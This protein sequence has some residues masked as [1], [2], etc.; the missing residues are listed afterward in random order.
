MSWQRVFAVHHHDTALRSIVLALLLLLLS[1]SAAWMEENTALSPS[2]AG[3]SLALSSYGRRFYLTTSQAD[4]ASALAA[5]DA[6]YHM[7]S[8]WEIAD[9]S[10]LVYDTGRGCSGADAGT[11]P[12]TYV[13]GWA[14]TGYSTANGT[15]M[16]GMGNCQAWTSKSGT[17]Y[18]SIATLS[19]N[20]TGDVKI[21]GTAWE[22]R[23]MLCDM[24]RRV[25]CVQN[26][27]PSWNMR[28]YYLTE[29]KYDGAEALLAC[30]NG[31]EMASIW[32]ILDPSNA[33]YD[34][35]VGLTQADSGQ[36][37]PTYRDAEGW[38]RTGYHQS[39]GEDYAGVANCQAWT[40]K[41]GND[42]GTRAYILSYWSDPSAPAST[43]ERDLGVWMA[44]T[45]K[46]NTALPVWC[47]RPPL[48]DYLPAVMKEH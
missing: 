29:E 13:M 26:A 17:D 8:I 7:A 39:S 3:L 12:P 24:P 46:C 28:S 25:W 37:P 1:A 33:V 40:S 27:S 45:A 10:N 38:V 42:Y 30:T 44:V 34:T 19:A 31:Y 11:G 6:G 32:D 5:C 18:G 22:P 35:S 15:N 36:G 47:V 9:V 43:I 4:G 16:P 14:R 48:R 2:G 23:T 41:S 20:W 21:D